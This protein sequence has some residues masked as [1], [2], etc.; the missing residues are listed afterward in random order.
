MLGNHI[1][2]YVAK[3]E[4]KILMLKSLLIIGSITV[5]FASVG[6]TSMIALNGPAPS[7]AAAGRTGGIFD[8]GCAAGGVWAKLA[9]HKSANTVTQKISLF[10]LISLLS[11]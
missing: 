9:Q 7:G 10:I 6:S 8:A 11:G 5:C 2:G 1:D 4:S 3:P